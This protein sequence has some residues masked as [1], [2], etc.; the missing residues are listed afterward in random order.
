MA[1]FIFSYWG[2]F[3]GVSL[4]TPHVNCIS[5]NANAPHSVSFSSFLQL[6]REPFQSYD[7][8]KAMA[9]TSQQGVH[10]GDD[11]DTEWKTVVLRRPVFQPNVYEEDDPAAEWEIDE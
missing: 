4:I 2:L 11:T 5:R 9:S 3:Q 1:C 6:N 8:M 7:V 10:Q